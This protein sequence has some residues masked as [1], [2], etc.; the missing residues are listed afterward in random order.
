MDYSYIIIPLIVAVTS[1]AVKLLTD[2]IKGNF[3]IKNLLITYGGMPS[4]HTAF[5]T[6]IATLIGLRLGWD[7]PLF[8]VALV[9]GII[10]IR[11][12]ITFRNILGQQMK[13]RMGHSLPE[14]LVGI[15]W[16]AV[17]TYFLTL[18]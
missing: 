12:A 3:N 9:F 6:S 11:D 2:G 8:A 15:L 16:G 10:V 13:Q 7:S 17:I 1:Q 14:V 4:T 5:A 18:L